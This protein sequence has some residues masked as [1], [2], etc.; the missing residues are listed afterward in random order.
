MNSQIKKLYFH[1]TRKLSKRCKTRS[2]LGG[3]FGICLGTRGGRLL[4][5]A[6]KGK[7]AGIANREYFE[8]DLLYICISCSLHLPI[9][10]NIHN[11]QLVLMA[12]YLICFKWALPVLPMHGHVQYQ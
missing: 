3:Q 9:H 7:N 11:M 2:K 4:L 5:V 1:P 12:K 6:T 10:N 8:I